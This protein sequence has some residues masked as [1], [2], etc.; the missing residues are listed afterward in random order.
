MP[1]VD[2]QVEGLEGAP[3]MDALRQ[4]GSAKEL[5]SDRQQTLQRT[6]VAQQLK[7]IECMAAA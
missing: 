1:L 7:A 2:A 5:G 6:H 4:G 3:E